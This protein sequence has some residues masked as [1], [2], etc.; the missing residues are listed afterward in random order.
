MNI[1]QR[2]EE[3]RQ[4]AEELRR[5]IHE[6]NYRYYVL[7]RPVISDAE[8]DALMAELRAIEARFPELITPD[9]PTQR[10]GAPPREEFGTV[11]HTVPMLSLEDARN[12]EELRAF[13]AR[14]HR[15]L[16]LP[17]DQPIRYAAEPKYD[18]LS[19]ELVYEGG[20]LTV[21]STRGNGTVGED[22]TPNV[23]TI[24]TVPLRLRALPELPLPERLEVR[25]EVLISR[26]DF[27]KL[28]QAREQEGLPP[29]ANP[30][31]AAAGSL[32]QL[33]PTIT[34]SRPLVFIAWGIGQR[35]LPAR[36]HSEVLDLL[37]RLG[38]RVADPRRVCR[39]IEEVIAFYRELEEARDNFPFE[40]DG[41]VIKVNDMDL[42]EPLGTTARSPRWAVA[43]K[44]KPRERTTRLMDVRFQVGRTG[45][46][47]P[48]A[49]L[50]P[51]EVGGVVVSRATLHNFEEVARKDVR[52][53]DWVFVRR[54]GDVI[55]EIVGPI[56]ERRTGEERPILP[57][58]RCPVCQ[59]EV[60]KEGA[61]LKCINLACPAKLE[62][63][64][65]HLASRRALD[66]EGLGKKT[67]EL[68][69]QRG[70]VKDPAD[71]FYLTPKDFQD[72]PGFAEKSIQNLMQAIARARHVPLHRFL[73]ALGI[74]GVGEQVARVLVRHFHTLEALMKADEQALMEVEGIGPELA[75]NITRFFREPHN[76][77]IL[78]KFL[79]VLSLEEET[80]PSTASDLFQGKTFVFTGALSSMTRDRARELVESLG[81]RV[82][83]SVS[84]KTDYVVVGENPG[85]K[86]TRA[87]ALGVPTLTEETFLD[88]LKQAGVKP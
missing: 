61:Y 47:T 45:I 29:F 44:F 81:G 31:N 83:S 86:L 85:S 53:G 56:P 48:V 77:K 51:V 21:A 18:G 59:G 16:R 75:R 78:A 55:P 5:L 19:C 41:V 8:Y 87:Q 58:D 72:L 37:H 68:L 79:Q 22:V 88:M 6:H 9:S 2:I 28:N 17:P 26:E 67:A 76:R 50:E 3:A 15:F 35:T 40:L 10:V 33:D 27:E 65:R 1:P 36:T 73:Y 82:S 4:R 23:R 63:A 70:K 20:M 13:D 11:R 24:P 49:L 66:I 54:A 38:F 14:V 25:G 46:I 42:W 84:R 30:R 57:P 34:A 32:R 69:V 64:L 7:N 52:I 39:G 43:A 74:P 80:A 71:V 62:A 12:E 60:V